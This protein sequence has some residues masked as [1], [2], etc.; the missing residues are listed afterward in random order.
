ML[1]I[2]EV[3]VLLSVLFSPSKCIGS[4][5]LLTSWSDNRLEFAL[6]TLLCKHTIPFQFLEKS[7]VVMKPDVLLAVEMPSHI[8]GFKLSL[9]SNLFSKNDLH[10]SAVFENEPDHAIDFFH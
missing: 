4:L 9:S 2:F 8:L 3:R 7:G 10:L 5:S 1:E 6:L